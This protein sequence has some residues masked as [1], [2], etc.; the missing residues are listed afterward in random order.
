LSDRWPFDLTGRRACITGAAGG[1][2][3]A[4][5]RAFAQ[6]GAEPVLADLD[7][8]GVAALARELGE[9]T[10][11]HR[12]DQADLGS[13]AALA[14]A[15]ADVDVLV[16]NAGILAVGP[17]LEAEPEEIARIITVD[18]IGP[19]CLCRHIGARMIERGRGGVIVNI[20][21]QLAFGGAEG[22]GAY[23]AAKAGLVQFTRTAAVE[24]ARH[25]VR[26]VAIAPGRLLT[27]MTAPMLSDPATYQ[28]GLARIPAGRYGDPAEIAR[29]AVFLA[30]DAAAYI[31][32]ETIIADGGYVLG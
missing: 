13:I 21:S 8:D 29:L 32:G 10:A 9:A 30:S 1:L 31:V 5:A 16:N 28:A 20:A 7:A 22:R 12:Y 3:S 26:V 23:A 6:A 14:Q 19:I 17:I 11:W 15:V 18:L 2:G 4:L 27:P 25:G 24:W